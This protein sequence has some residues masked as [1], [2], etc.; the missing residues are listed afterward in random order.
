MLIQLFLIF[1]SH[2]RPVVI[3]YWL[4]KMKDEDLKFHPASFLPSPRFSFFYPPNTVIVLVRVLWEAQTKAELEMHK[5]SWA[6]VREGLGGRSRADLRPWRSG[7]RK[8]GGVG[9]VF[10]GWVVLRNSKP[11][12]WRD[13]EQRLL[14]REALH[15]AAT[16]GSGPLPCSVIGWGPRRASLPLEDNS[17]SRRGHT[18]PRASPPLKGGLHGAPPRPPHFYSSSWF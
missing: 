16:A 3:L 10:D 13:P 15:W 12:W 11:G 2:Y 8:A 9:R 4:P 6:D 7:A 18:L 5:V 17:A 14:I 1:F